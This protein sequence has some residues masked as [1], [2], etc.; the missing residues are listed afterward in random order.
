MK[1][2]KKI[3]LALTTAAVSLVQGAAVKAE[4]PHDVGDWDF[5]AAILF[6]QESDDRVQAVEPIITAKKYLD[7]DETLSFKLT[8]DALTGASPSGAVPTDSPQ[9][10]T[11]PS[12]RGIYTINNNEQPLDDTF[13]DTRVAFNTAWEAPLSNGLKMG[14]NGNIST[15]YDYRSFSAGTTLTYDANNKNTTYATGFSLGYDQIDP[16][17]G[18]PIA[19]A[20]MAAVGTSQPKTSETEDKF[21]MDVLLGVTQIIDKYSLFQLNYSLTYSNGYLTD[22]YKVI[23][24]VDASTGNPL[25]ADAGQGLPLVIFESRPDSRIKHVYSAS[26]SLLS[27][28]AGRFLYAIFYRWKSANWCRVW[29]RGFVRLSIGRVYG[30]YDWLGIWQ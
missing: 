20:E 24:V 28:G 7:T 17:G 30:Q 18:V 9:T 5:G 15:E 21:L 8:F 22:P 1:T 3:S 13:R 11:K 2:E 14:L 26:S 27:A 23:S 4:N 19:F 29:C 16:V 12:G 6:Y 25:I 10:F